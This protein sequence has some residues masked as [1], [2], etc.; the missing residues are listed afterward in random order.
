[1]K[2][3]FKFIESLG[4]WNFIGVLFFWNFIFKILAIEF[5]LEQLY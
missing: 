3:I 4:S 1:M 5:H 2:L